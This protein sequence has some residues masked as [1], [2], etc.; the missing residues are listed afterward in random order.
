VAAPARL[1]GFRRCGPV[2]ASAGQ[3]HAPDAVLMRRGRYGPAVVTRWT[4]TDVDGLTLREFTVDD[5]R[6]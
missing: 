4:G 3:G 6:R 5:A 1:R 2:T